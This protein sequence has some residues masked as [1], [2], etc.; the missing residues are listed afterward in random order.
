M[1]S[2]TWPINYT[3]A[4][5]LWLPSLNM[6]HFPFQHNSDYGNP[7]PVQI[8]VRALRHV[9]VEDNVDP[10]DVHTSSKEIRSHQDSLAEALERLVLG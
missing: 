4:L 8:G 10:F 6:K 5:W 1:K 3:Q 9:V 2:K 7:Y